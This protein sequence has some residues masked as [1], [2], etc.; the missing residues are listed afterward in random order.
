MKFSFLISILF[1]IDVYSQE[2]VNQRPFLGNR[3]RG[4]AGQFQPPG[5][6][7]SS[8]P[9]A[10]VP[11][12]PVVPNQRHSPRRFRVGLNCPP[13]SPDLETR[14]VWFDGEIRQ[15]RPLTNF[16]RECT[17][18]F[19]NE[20]VYCSQPSICS[21]QQHC[22]QLEFHGFSQDLDAAIAKIHENHNYLTVSGNYPPLLYSQTQPNSGSSSSKCAVGK[23]CT[24]TMLEFIL[25]LA[26]LFLIFIIFALL[27]WWYNKRRNQ[28][29]G[30]GVIAQPDPNF[31]NGTPYALMEEGQVGEDPRR[32]TVSLPESVPADINARFMGKSGVPGERLSIQK[33]GETKSGED[34]L[35]KG[36][37][38]SLY[39]ENNSIA[40]EEGIV[41]DDL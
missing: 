30:P 35:D 5:G 27:Y 12:K 41:P 23:D 29:N 25:I 40:E 39:N 24:L 18:Y 10:V 26:S 13:P 19:R 17:D 9:P 16:A 21:N 8:H 20:C 36:R 15:V 37:S 7:Q 22:I 31:G 32:D 28:I 34:K 2:I 14:S 4:V 6:S 3:P 33:E 11:Q 38:I 1:I